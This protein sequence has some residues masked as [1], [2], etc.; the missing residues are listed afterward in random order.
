MIIPIE[1]LKEYVDTN[2]SSEEIAETFTSLG[3]LLDKPVETSEYGNEV[4]DLEHRMDRADWLSILGCARDFA[5]MENIELK[6]PKGFEGKGKAPKRENVVPITVECPDLVTRFTTKVIRNVKVGDSPEWMKQRLE[7]Y[8]I[9]SINNIVDVTNYVMIEYGQPLHAQ[10]LE[11]FEKKEIVIRRAKDGETLTTLDGTEIILTPEMFIL[12][13]NNEPITLGGIVGGKKTGVTAET[14]NIILDAGNYNQANIRHTSRKLGIRNETVSRSEKFLAPELTEVAVQRA[15]QLILELAGG[16]YYDNQDW[17]PQKTEEKIMN[18]RYSRVSVLSGKEPDPKRVKEILKGLGYEIV[19]EKA[20]ELSVKIPYFRTDVLV[21]DDIVADFLRI[22]NYKNIKTVMLAQ[23]PPTNITSES[24]KTKDELRQ[25]LVK[26]GGIEY[27]TNPLVPADESIENQIKL[28]NA[29]SEEQSALRT[30]IKQTLRIIAKEHGK[31]EKEG[32]IFELGRIYFKE[33]GNYKEE[34]RL[35]AMQVGK[36][37]KMEIHK[38]LK[39]NLTTLFDEL[40]IGDVHYRKTCL[41]TAEIYQSDEKLGHLD[42][43]SFTLYS[44]KISKAER[45]RKKIVREHTNVSTL[46]ISLLVPEDFEM[47]DVI[48]D[49]ENLNT[50]IKEVRVENEYRGEGIQE[51]RRSILLS[52][53]IEDKNLTN[54]DTQTAHDQLLRLV[55]TYPQIKIRD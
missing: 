16:E 7:K 43:D 19:R 12:A 48:Y 28:E 42:Y 45:T 21:E 4:L 33:G 44:D 6:P 14:K 18:V 3:L 20:K 30:D 55:E 54:T 46:D 13:Q 15:V 32:L 51:D 50:K 49:M 29:L 36:G 31:R 53:R 23:A 17:Y 37:S 26:I 25:A 40:S 34:R 47:G 9:P 35:T 41:G 38:A 52:I 27:I 1:W 39:V 24:F 8:G 22:S 11:I 2:K 10:D 5:A